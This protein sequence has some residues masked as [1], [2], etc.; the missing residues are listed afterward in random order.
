MPLRNMREIKGSYDEL[1][2]RENYQSTNTDD[3]LKVILTD[4]NDVINA[5]AKLRTIYPHILELNYANKRTLMQENSFAQSEQMLEKT[6]LEHF[7]DLYF[8]QNNRELDSAQRQYL[9]ELINKLWEAE[10]CGR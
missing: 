5:L 7:N 9:T 4:E 3:Y 6:P 1:C 2:Q 10:Q 8:K